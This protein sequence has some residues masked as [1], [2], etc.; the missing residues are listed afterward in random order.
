MMPPS[1]LAPLRDAPWAGH[2]A[3]GF[4]PGIRPLTLKLLAPLSSLSAPSARETM[5]LAPQPIQA[6]MLTMRSWACP[7]RARQAGGPP[8]SAPFNYKQVGPG[9]WGSQATA[10]A[11]PCSQRPPADGLGRRATG[12]RQLGGP[13]DRCFSAL[14][15]VSGSRAVGRRDP[16]SGVGTGALTPLL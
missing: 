7:L 13:W 3:L 4:S 2:V 15:E 11:G 8:I 6:G 10:A 1:P 12:T 9:T 5:R 16:G 14:R